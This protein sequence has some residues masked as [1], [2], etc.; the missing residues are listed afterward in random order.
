LR[1]RRALVRE[2]HVQF[3]AQHRVNACDVDVR[4]RVILRAPLPWLDAADA[5]DHATGGRGNRPTG[6][7]VP[8]M[9]VGI[10]R[11]QVE[12]RHRIPRRAARRQVRQVR[13]AFVVAVHHD[14]RARQPQ[15]ARVNWIKDAVEPRGRRAD[16]PLP[17]E[18]ELA[19]A[20]FPVTARRRIELRVFRERADV[21]ADQ[22]E[23]ERLRRLPLPPRH[24][25][26][27][28]LQVTVQVARHRDHF[29]PARIGHDKPD[30][31]RAR[32]AA[33]A[34]RVTLCRA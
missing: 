3:A 24:R 22:H 11:R 26:Q 10:D 5:A 19:L 34:L 13:E 23:L 33:A 32:A 28:E 31:N 29:L 6:R 17:E 8:D 12:W 15:P 27:R 20:A 25:A 21:A 16:G 2:Q 7:Q 14:D 4:H 1:L 30:R 9:P 18:F